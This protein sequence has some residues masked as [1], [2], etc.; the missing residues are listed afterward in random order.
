MRILAEGRA[1]AAFPGVAIG[2]HGVTHVRLTECDD[3]A[4]RRELVASRC[5]L[6]D[7]LGRAVTALSYPHGAVD[8]RVRDAAVAAGYTLGFCSR[9]DVN[10]AQRDAMLLCRTDV[11]GH[12]SLRV[13]RQ[14]L[15]GDWDWLRWRPQDLAQ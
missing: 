13:F 7:R 4:L 14:K 6:E 9:F 15:D 11:H 3:A 2:S 10:T 8:R 1:M 5:Y 12:D